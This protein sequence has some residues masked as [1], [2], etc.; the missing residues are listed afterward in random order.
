V[1][2]IED[3]PWEVT[4]PTDCLCQTG[5]G[6]RTD[7]GTVPVAVVYGARDQAEPIA[8]LMAA[9]RDLLEALREADPHD[10]ADLSVIRTLAQSAL[11]EPSL[12]G[13]QKEAIAELLQRYARFLRVSRAAIAKATELKP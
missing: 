9:S 6:I 1:S 2:E 5:I 13:Q 4:G 3:G 8:T 10:D 12:R 11:N 7:N